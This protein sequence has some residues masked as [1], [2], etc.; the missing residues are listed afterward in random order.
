MPTDTKVTEA[1]KSHPVFKNMEAAT[2]DLNLSEQE[3][4]LYSMH[5]NNLY[6]DGGVNNQ[7]GS[8]STLYQTV[9]QHEGQYYSIPTVWDGKREVSQW[10]RP[11]DGS[12]HDVANQTTLDNV[13]KIGWDKFP[14]SA[15]P[16]ELD[17]R[18]QQMHGYMEDDTRDYLN[19]VS[20]TNQ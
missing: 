9:E 20:N 14:S 15:N 18:Y 12:V 3:Q 13:S 16:D 19:S 11:S 6:G 7:D 5:L 4:N 8:R 2:K 17:N 1:D 10:T